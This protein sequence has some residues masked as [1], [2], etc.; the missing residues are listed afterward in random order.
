MGTNIYRMQFCNCVPVDLPFKVQDQASGGHAPHSH[1]AVFQ[2]ITYLSLDAHT[3]HHGDAVTGHIALIMY[4]CL[5]FCLAFT[6]RFSLS[7]L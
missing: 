4:F 7:G 2:I 3:G 5:C 6:D 1:M